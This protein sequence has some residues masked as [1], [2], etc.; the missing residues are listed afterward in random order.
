MDFGSVLWQGKRGSGGLD[1]KYQKLQNQALVFIIGAFPNSPF[2]ALEVEA[3]ILPLKVR[4]FKH[5]FYYALRLL[6][7]QQ[8]HPVQ[9]QL[10]DPLQDEL[11]GNTGLDLE[12]FSPLDMHQTQISRFR[13]LLQPFSR[14]QRL[15]ENN[16]IWLAP[17]VIPSIHVNISSKTN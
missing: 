12:I 15:E 4:Q 7:L 1:N 13:A 10:I 14:L 16:S 9:Q 8:M 3:A 5:T 2:K 6:R 17:W 11:N